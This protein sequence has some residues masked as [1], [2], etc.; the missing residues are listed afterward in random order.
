[1]PIPYVI[2]SDVIYPLFAIIFIMSNHRQSLGGWGER[3]AA[4]YLVKKGYIIL[5]HHYTCRY[6]EI[7]LVAKEAN[8]LVFIE[9]KTRLGINCGLPEQSVNRN[10]INKLKKAI[11]AYLS[12]N[13]HSDYRLDVVAI[14]V[15]NKENDFKVRHYRAVSD[16]F[17]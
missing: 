1:M 14:N 3:I 2:I 12:Q 5:N 7:D 8:Q 17:P 4:D 9:V 11:F 10:K 13:N 6:G 16:I 15:S